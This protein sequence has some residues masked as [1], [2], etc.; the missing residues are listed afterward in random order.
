[1]SLK[2]YNDTFIYSI[3]L[4]LYRWM[5]QLVMQKLHALPQPKFLVMKSIK[6][7]ERGFLIF[8]EEIIL[9]LVLQPQMLIK[10]GRL[11]FLR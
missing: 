5:L 1:M 4:E 11:G 8:L 7:I 3:Y 6:N 2:E 9:V 10:K